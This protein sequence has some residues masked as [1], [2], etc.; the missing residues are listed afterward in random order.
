MCKSG[1]W[2][3]CQDGTWPPIFYI[4]FS[5][6]HLRKNGKSKAHCSSPHLHPIWIYSDVRIYLF[7]S[8][9]HQGISEPPPSRILS[10]CCHLILCC[11]LLCT[12]AI[13]IIF[14][15]RLSSIF[16][17]LSPSQELSSSTSSS[18]SWSFLS[19]PS[20]AF[21]F[22]AAYPIFPAPQG[23]EQLSVPIF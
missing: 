13:F 16:T 18:P 21:A 14:T 5:T 7:G 23:K 10:F 15:L 6:Q 8:W 1:N 9:E 12:T 4:G 17:L 20:P 22:R 3:F 2:G 11:C 19:P